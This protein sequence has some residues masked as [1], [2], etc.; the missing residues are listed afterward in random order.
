M[1]DLREAAKIALEALETEWWETGDAV[2]AKQEEARKA[3]RQALSDGVVQEIKLYDDECCN[4]D[5]NE[6]RNCVRRKK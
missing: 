3:L 4:H 6:G 5:C 1:T 2:E